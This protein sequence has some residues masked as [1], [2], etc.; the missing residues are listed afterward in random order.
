MAY[1]LCSAVALKSISESVG[2]SVM[3]ILD[4]HYIN[5]VGNDPVSP[6][7]LK[8]DK[9]PKK[10]MYATF[11]LIGLTV[12]VMCIYN[13]DCARNPLIQTLASRLL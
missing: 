7:Y 12:D 5:N 11:W 10:P 8:V 1:F 2:L 3:P 4:Q 9:Q 13:S 6:R